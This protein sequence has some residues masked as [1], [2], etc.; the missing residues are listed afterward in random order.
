MTT[1]SNLRLSASVYKDI[2]RGLGRAESG[3]RH[4]NL[5]PFEIFVISLVAGMLFKSF[6]AFVM[7]WLCLHVLISVREIAQV[8]ITIFSL[9]L[10]SLIFAI[11]FQ[12]G[13]WGAAIVWGLTGFLVSFG[14]HQRSLQYMQDMASGGE[15]PLQLSDFFKALKKKQE[16]RSQIP[17]SVKQSVLKRDGAKCLRCSCPINLS[18]VHV[19][20][21]AKGGANHASNIQILCSECKSEKGDQLATSHEEKA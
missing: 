11:A 21:I 5:I 19:V 4:R 17:E 10:G 8:F 13:V 7:I 12:G 2:S 9:F 15:E 18:F 3:R 14:V 20:P 16:A 1:N 6:L